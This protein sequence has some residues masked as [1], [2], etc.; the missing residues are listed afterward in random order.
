MYISQSRVVD[1]NDRA[2]ARCR[3]LSYGDDGYMCEDLDRI[4]EEEQCRKK[5]RYSHAL[6][7]IEN[8][9]RNDSNPY[10]IIGWCL[11]QPVYYRP[12]YSAQFFVDPARR[13]EGIGRKLI[14]HARYR[15]IKP[16]YVHIDN[17]NIDFFKEFPELCSDYAELAK[18]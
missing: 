17:D 9:K 14:Q 18:E 6:L 15:T 2:L 4:L 16:V 13:R 7:A 10:G 8:G 11:L 12:R 3:E 1:L 5:Y